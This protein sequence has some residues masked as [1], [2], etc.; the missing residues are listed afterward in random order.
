MGIKSNYLIIIDNFF[1]L[2]YF[3]FIFQMDD[4]AAVAGFATPNE[5]KKDI[6]DSS[7]QY[8]KLLC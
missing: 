5:N 8:Y 6:L 4:I 7:G 3:N 2:T 1:I